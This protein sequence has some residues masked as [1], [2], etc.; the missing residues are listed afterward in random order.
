MTGLTIGKLAEE[1]GVGVETVR[2]YERKGLIAQPVKPLKGFR[3]YSEEEIERIRFIRQAQDL[4]FSLAEI[5][6]LLKLKT[7]PG[8]QCG[9]VRQQAVIKLNDVEWK[10]DALMRMKAGLVRVIE[11][12]PGQG[13]LDSCTIIQAI[14]QPELIKKRQ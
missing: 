13:G 1:T 11:A 4:G 8:T 9:V 12:C 14:E 6:D 10:I 2:F 5:A 7:T 3:E